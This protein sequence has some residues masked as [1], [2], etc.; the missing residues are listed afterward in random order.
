MVRVF[1]AGFVLSLILVEDISAVNYSRPRGLLDSAGGTAVS[2]R[3]RLSRGSLGQPFETTSRF[4]EQYS[5]LTG[6][7][8]LRP[9]TA[10][11]LTGDF[12]GDLAVSWPLRWGS[13]SPRAIPN[14][15]H[16]WTWIATMR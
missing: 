6:F 12:N 4:S 3:F 16:A 7:L 8:H 2:E 10:V 15:M 11:T 14:S 1:L 5:V 13:G 9:G